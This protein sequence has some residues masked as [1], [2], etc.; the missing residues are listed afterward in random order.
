MN[1][2]LTIV[3]AAALAATATQASAETRGVTKTEIT[4]GIHT[5]LSG[6]A[7]TYGVSSAN[8]VKMRLDEANDA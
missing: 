1:G 8:G 4:L 5:D 2:M 3:A 7:A 6:V